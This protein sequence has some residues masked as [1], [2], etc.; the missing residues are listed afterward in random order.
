[1]A[2]L[3]ILTAPDPRLKVKAE[4]VRDITTVQT[5]IDDMLETAFFKVVVTGCL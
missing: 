2:V 1:M 5:L 4:K 3:E